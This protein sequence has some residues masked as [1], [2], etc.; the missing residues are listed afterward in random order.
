[1]LQYLPE[2]LQLSD[3][4]LPIFKS[5]TMGVLS[6]FTFLSGY[7][8]KKYDFQDIQD[9]LVFYKKK[10]PALLSSVCHSNF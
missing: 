8:L 10:I 2:E 3:A 5:V 4:T 1:M 7:F 9:A 6:C